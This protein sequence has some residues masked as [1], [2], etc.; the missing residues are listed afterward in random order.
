MKFL[1]REQRFSARCLEAYARAGLPETLAV[2]AAAD[3]T[4]ILL[5]DEI[6]CFGV[7][8][9]A[10]IQALA[11][12][13][14]GPITLRINSPGGDVFDGMAIY[15]ALKARTAPVTVIIDGLAASAGSFV[16]MAGDKIEMPEASMMMIH[17]AWGLTAGNAEDMIGTAE[18]LEK[19]DG[20]LA[21]IYAARTGKPAG[22]MMALMAAETWLTSSEAQ[23]AGFATA[24]ASAPPRMAAAAALQPA[25]RIVAA[26]RAALPDYDPDGDGD[27]DAEETLTLIQ[28]AQVLLDNA[29]AS[30]T[31][32]DEDET[33]GTDDQGPDETA[34]TLIDPAAAAAEA[35]KAQ[36]HA[37]RLRRLRLAMAA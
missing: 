33:A 11:Q 37:V 15:N 34:T 16:A 22:D 5:Y 8:A 6:G 29:V 18:V 12:A 21:D 25:N 20:Q 3:A 10:F 19:I 17:R 28:A 26:L 35:A 36:A 2:R 27:N 13:G 9:K 1:S 32:E 24:V 31:G 23:E 14:D 4:E 30:L 7:T